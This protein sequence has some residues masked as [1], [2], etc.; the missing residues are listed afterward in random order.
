MSPKPFGTVNTSHSGLTQ[1]SGNKHHNPC[2]SISVP[3]NRVK[4][5]ISV[6]LGS[7]V[8]AA[9]VLNSPSRERAISIRTTFPSRLRSQ[10]FDYRES[11]SEDNVDVGDSPTQMI[12][13]PSTSP[14]YRPPC[15]PHPFACDVSEIS[16]ACD[17]LSDDGSFQ[18]QPATLLHEALA[19]I[20]SLIRGEDGSEFNIDSECF[21]ELDKDLFIL[22]TMDVFQENFLNSLVSRRRHF[23]DVPEEI[24]EE[25]DQRL[26]LSESDSSSC[27]SSL[28]FSDVDLKVFFL[29]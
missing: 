23:V 7:P 17:A 24:D 22:D 27:N 10:F 13:I 19:D 1:R 15:R 11:E 12:L 16:F 14:F 6:E 8:N 25:T 9:S 29:P 5:R 3:E 26:G 21:R 4:Y 18:P 28:F 20:P 2:L